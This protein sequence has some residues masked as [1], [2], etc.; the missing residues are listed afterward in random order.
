MNA[1]SLR[2]PTAAGLAAA[3]IAGLTIRAV[4]DGSVAKVGGVALYG[5]MIYVTLVLLQPRLTPRSAATLAGIVCWTV[6]FAQL[7][8]FPAAASSHSTLVRLALGSTFNPPDLASYLVGIL[9]G[10]LA[11]L[12]FRQLSRTSSGSQSTGKYG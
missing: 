9:L 5:T 3:L 10:V 12:A 6:E 2:V 1:V 7:T 4:T 8:P 11:Q